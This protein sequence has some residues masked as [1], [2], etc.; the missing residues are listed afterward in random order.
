MES[1]TNRTKE[2]RVASNEPGQGNGAAPGRALIE[3]ALR[4]GAP[5]LDEA[6]GKQF[7]AAYG[8]PVPAGATVAS[9][10][11]AVRV[12]GEIGYPV[13]MKGSSP[14]VQHKTDAGLV[15]L[16]VADDAEV[17]DGYRTL[18]TRAAA[19]GATLDG[20]LV[21]H[22]VTGKRE[23]VVGLIRDH[24]F[25]PVV[26]F[27]LGGIFTEALHDVAFAVAPLDDADA[28]ELLDQIE[29]KALLG[30][31]RGSPA[32]DRDALVAD[33]SRPSPRWPTIIPRSGR[34]T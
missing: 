32:V 12:A 11:E 25:G 14:Q 16:G 19:A 18:E 4:A 23:F 21:E 13:V 7:F 3:E 27:G 22:M 15:I 2:A 33:R 28:H 24:L 26:M 1:L 9:P 34:S 30:P 17:R 5:A 8:I 31:F 10:D 6:A 20:V 29:A